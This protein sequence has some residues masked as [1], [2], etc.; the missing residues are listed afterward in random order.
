MTEILSSKSLQLK[1]SRKSEFTKNFTAFK[2]FKKIIGD[3]KE[4]LFDNSDNLFLSKIENQYRTFSSL[5]NS[6][7]TFTK[8][9]KDN[10]K[11][12]KNMLAY[13]KMDIILKCIELKYLQESYESSDNSANAMIKLMR[14][15]LNALCEFNV[16]DFIKAIKEAT[17]NKN[18]GESLQFPVFIAVRFDKDVADS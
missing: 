5:Y 14:E 15:S 11:Y 3:E 4:M 8:S 17:T 12:L 18:G 7:D 2:L 16:S 9:V 13:E 1:A 6:N 10:P